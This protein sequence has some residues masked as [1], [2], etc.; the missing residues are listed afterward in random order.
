M[1]INAHFSTVVVK[2]KLEACLSLI[3]REANDN[4]PSQRSA[5]LEMKPL[6]F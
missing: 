6:Y 4:G 1:L 5:T 3:A 2:A